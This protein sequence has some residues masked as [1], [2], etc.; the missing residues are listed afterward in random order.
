MDDWAELSIQLKNLNNDLEHQLNEKNYKAAFE[1][2]HAITN[3]GIKLQ[4]WT[5]KNI[6]VV[7]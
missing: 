5:F 2:S 6:N 4:I 7:Q 1:T 3:I